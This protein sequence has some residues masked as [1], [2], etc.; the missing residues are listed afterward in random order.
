[1]N[2]LVASI[3]LLL[4]IYHQITTWF[5]LFPW[6]DID[7]LSRKD[8]LLEAGTNGLLM[9]TGFVCLLHANT[10]F[11]HYYPLI[12]YPFLLSGEFFQWWLPFL[13]GSFSKSKVNFDY[14]KRYSRTT[15]FIP[16]K[17]GTRTPDANH[18]VL[19]LL[20]LATTVLVYIV[21]LST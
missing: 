15:K 10:G 20:T 11:Y 1:M 19:H 16:Q 18:T 8:I 4:L 17:S 7:N 9:G 6:N 21:R 13:S 12:Y 3:A 2:F 5:P 14:E